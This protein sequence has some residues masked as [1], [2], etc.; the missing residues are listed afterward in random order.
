MLNT[1]EKKK[2]KIPYKQKPLCYN[3]CLV[4]LSGVIHKKGCVTCNSKNQQLLFTW[5]Y[6]PGLLYTSQV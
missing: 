6:K 4:F 5:S 3:L 2:A 1:K